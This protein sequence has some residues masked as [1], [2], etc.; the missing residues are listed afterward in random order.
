M[1]KLISLCVAFAL[2]GAGC[3]GSSPPAPA[4]NP[5]SAPSASAS[6]SSVPSSPESTTVTATVSS[7]E[8]TPIDAT[9]K[10]YT[11]KAGD[12]SFQ[13]PTNGRYA[14]T[15]GTSFSDTD[16]VATENGNDTKTTLAVGTQT[17]C[18]TSSMGGAAGTAYY[19]D[20]YTTKYGSQYVAISFE[21][22]GYS[23]GALNCAFANEHGYSTSPT[24]CVA[25][26]EA[27]YQAT[28]DQIVGTFK[29]L[30]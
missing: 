13:W 23:A 24:S 7:T 11:S 22:K 26:D 2:F 28:L 16:C 4:S 21:K 27:V 5:S 29:M 6:S 20:I 25:F 9:W 8:L 30:K 17:F 19:R 12:F 18:H 14:P 15:W 10:T 3:F 1:K